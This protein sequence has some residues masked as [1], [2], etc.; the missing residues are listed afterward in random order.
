[1]I[2]CD[3]CCCSISILIRLSVGICH[4][5]YELTLV[6]VWNWNDSMWC[7]Y[8]NMSPFGSTGS[9][10]FSCTD[11]EVML[12]TTAALRFIGK[13]VDVI[14]VTVR[15]AVQP[16]DVHAST[17]TAYVVCAC[18]SVNWTSGDDEPR[19]GFTH[20]ITPTHRLPNEDR[21]TGVI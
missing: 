1:M 18:N 3:E 19:R 14:K 15:L 9:V 2:K 8:L 20:N 7:V 17:C 13:S 4:F 6:A 5:Q 21:S 11:V 16:A 10:Q 12:W